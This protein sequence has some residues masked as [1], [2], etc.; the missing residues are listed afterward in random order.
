MHDIVGIVERSPW[1]AEIP[2]SGLSQLATAAQI[3]DCPVGAC[4]YSVGQPTTAIYCVL[5]GRV[6]VSISSAL[7]HEFTIVDLDSGAWLGEPCLIDD[8]PRMC[9]AQVKEKARVLSITRNVVLEV[10]KQFPVLYRNLFK[11][12]IRNE[13]QLYELMGGMLFYPLRVRL[14]GRLLIL[15]EEHGEV[16]PEG[17]LLETRLRQNDFAQLAMGS[18]QRVNKIFREWTERGILSMRGENYLVNDMNG[19]RAELDQ[20]GE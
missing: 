5:E 12:S 3:K 2:E 10:G 7:G 6:R 18:R 8:E 4:L 9:T 20:D 11:N 14:A 19:L 16:T 17:V 1:F 13:R 15:L